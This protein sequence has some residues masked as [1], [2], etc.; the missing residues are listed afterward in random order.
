[1]EH[2]DW[3]PLKI[4]STLQAKKAAAP[5]VKVS[6]DAIRS[7]KLDEA[8]GPIKTKHLSSE[9]RQNMIQVRTQVLKKTQVELNNLCQFAPN[10]IRD[11]EAGK[12]TPS[13]GQLNVLSRMLKI[14]LKLE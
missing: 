11:I 10:S 8:D 6:A 4:T 1:M 12:L 2:Q 7:R 9:S 3:A 5:P 14:S 13:A